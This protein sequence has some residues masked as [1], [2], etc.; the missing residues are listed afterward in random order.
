MTVAAVVLAA[1]PESALA[2][3]DGQPAVRRIADGAWAGGALPIVIVS[4]DPEGAVAGALAG[5]STTLAEPVPKPHGNPAAQ[6]AR[7]VAVARELV[8]G[9]DAVLIWPARLAWVGPET[10]TSLIEAH[11]L[12]R[13]SLLCPTYE[14][15]RGWPVLL[16]VAHAGAL[17]GLGP[18]RMPPQILED[19]IAAGVP[20]R[21]IEL[22]DPGVIHDIS[23]P[24]SELPAY[25]GPPE[26]AT[27]H[28]HEW[29]AALADLP[30]ET[31]LA[32][33]SLAPYGQAV[34]EDPDQPG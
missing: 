2:D 25:A 14:G 28:T 19:V 8:S 9:V 29:G 6:M 4:F 18:D 20:A 27:P 23:T 13:G 21:T 11:G 16:P 10:V 12:D 15:Q 7:G 33:P 26:P 3:A 22:G 1:S 34:A 5:S 17:D 24:R 30:E 32:G 31:P